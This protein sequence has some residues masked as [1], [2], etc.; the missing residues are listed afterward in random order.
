M[1]HGL[2]ICFCFAFCISSICCAIGDCSSK[3]VDAVV[4]GSVGGREVERESKVEGGRRRRRRQED[5]ND[6]FLPQLLPFFPPRPPSTIQT[7]G[8]FFFGTWRRGGG[9]EEEEEVPRELS[10]SLARFSRSILSF[11]PFIPSF[12]VGLNFRALTWI[13]L[14][15][16]PLFLPSFRVFCAYVRTYSRSHCQVRSREFARFFFQILCSLCVFCSASLSVV[17]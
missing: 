6:F 10:H 9:E 15:I 8:P 1:P 3:S 11:S 2:F 4:V 13:S 16:I 7:L 17:T 14:P 5:E 12:F